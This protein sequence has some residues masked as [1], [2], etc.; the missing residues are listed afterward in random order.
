MAL[1]GKTAAFSSH[2]L[3]MGFDRRLPV[4]T[5]CWHHSHGRGPSQAGL[6]GTC[7]HMLSCT[8]AHIHARAPGTR[9]ETICPAGFSTL[10]LP[11][12]HCLPYLGSHVSA[13][14]VLETPPAPFEPSCLGLRFNS[15][16]RLGLYFISAWRSSFLGGLRRKAEAAGFLSHMCSCLINRSSTHAHILLRSLSTAPCVH[17]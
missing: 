15:W 16:V 6:V 12:L 3:T 11:V 10:A 5:A 9:D 1:A 7:S 13:R 4:V 8:Q 2:S 17:C 14:T